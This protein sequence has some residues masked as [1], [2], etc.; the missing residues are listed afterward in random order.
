MH[1][2]PLACL[3]ASILVVSGLA[4]RA[5]PGEPAPAGTAAGK[6]ASAASKSRPRGKEQGRDK[7]VRLKTADGWWIVFTYR[8]P[9]KG[10]PVAVLAHGYGSGRAEWSG[11]SADL[12]K[13]GWGTLALDLRGHG[14]S[15]TGPAG[16][17]DFNFI[18]A[19]DGWNDAA[20][21]LDLTLEFL[22]GEKIPARRS[23]LV[24]ASLGAN[25]VSRAA[26][27]AP[28]LACVAL[29]SPGRD[30]RGVALDE[31]P[32]PKAKTLAAASPE[33]PYAYQTIV[34]FRARRSTHSLLEASRGHGVGMFQDLDFY[35]GFLSWLDAAAKR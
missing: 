14:D 4:R 9:R 17:V 15:H 2:T 21:D 20:K 1:T 6:P 5:L 7:T 12:H 32:G 26:A 25:L 35:K 31:D 18:D 29:L 27:S 22:R 10:R 33:D 8:A 23:C 11:L 3:L 16:R 28:G 24:G 34:G 30:Y 13:K 19:K